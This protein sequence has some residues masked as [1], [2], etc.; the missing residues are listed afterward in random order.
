MKDGQ[1][2]Q[3]ER[4]IENKSQSPCLT[5]QRHKDDEEA[6][7]IQDIGCNIWLGCFT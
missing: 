2:K 3:Q 4:N 7:G 6:E 1:R 5:A